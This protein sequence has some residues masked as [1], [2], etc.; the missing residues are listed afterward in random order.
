[1]AWGCPSNEVAA[2]PQGCFGCPRA[3]KGT[4]QHSDLHVSSPH[5]HVSP[6]GPIKRTGDVAPAGLAL[7]QKRKIQGKRGSKVGFPSPPK[8]WK[9]EGL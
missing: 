2:A 6:R 1:M 9:R 5:C 3:P 8:S 7:T 4:W